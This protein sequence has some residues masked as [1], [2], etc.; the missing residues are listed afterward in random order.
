MICEREEEIAAFIAQEYWTIDAEGEHTSAALSAQ[1]GRVSRP[2]GRAVQ[3]HQRGGGARGRTALKAPRLRRQS[4][5]LKVLTIDRKQRRRNPAPPFTTSTLQQEASR[6]LGFSAQRTMRLA[7]QLYEGVDIGEGSVGLITYMRTDSVSLAAEAV[8][9]IR[10]VI[11]RL[12]GKEAWPRSR[13]STRPSRRMPRKRTR[14]SARP[15]AAIVPADIEGNLDAD[16]FKL[17]ALIWKRA[18]ACQMAHARVRHRG[19][20]HAGRSRRAA[21]PPA[22]RQ[23]LDAG[24]ARL[25]RRLPGRARRCRRGRPI[26]CCRRCTRATRAAAHRARPEQHFT[27]PPPRFT[28]ASLVKALEE[29]GIG[30]PR[31]TPRSSRRCAIASTWRST[32]GASR[33]P[34]SARSCAAS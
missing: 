8:Q 10:E 29:H 28:E 7:Q 19:R 16:Q 32:A 21:A 30:R 24:Q 34:T 23:R 2:E 17:Y 4:R 12:Y 11:E 31:P 20:R 9:E 14:P 27:E 6:K 1:A 18:V 33:R 13:A 5:Q 22:A 15:P 26:T 3:L 25:H